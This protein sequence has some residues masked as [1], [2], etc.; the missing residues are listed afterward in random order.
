ML[1]C[2]PRTIRSITFVLFA[3]SALVYLGAW[4][5]AN[6]SDSGL[7]IRIASYAELLS[8]FF[9]LMLLA[10]S[11]TT[12]FQLADDKHLATR[13]SI[14]ILALALFIGFALLRFADFLQ[15]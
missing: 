4:M 7:A 1:L 12:K 11:I 3:I 14:L 5:L 9:G 6:G 8:V 10:T 13:L 15:V 2:S